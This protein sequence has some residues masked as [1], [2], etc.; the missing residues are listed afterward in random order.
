VL[1]IDRHHPEEPT[2]LSPAVTSL[3][4][5]RDL[6]LPPETVLCTAITRPTKLTSVI[7]RKDGDAGH[8]EAVRALF[9]RKVNVRYVVT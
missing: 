6:K 9:N 2:R 7:V 3:A 1:H 5:L 8:Q 4:N